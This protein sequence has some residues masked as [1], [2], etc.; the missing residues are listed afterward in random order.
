MQIKITHNGSS[1]EICSV[2]AQLQSW[3]HGGR[4]YIWQREESVWTSSCPILFPV[5]GSTVDDTVKIGGKPYGI[6]KHGFT[7]AMDFSLGK[8][9]DDFAELLL[10]DTPE[11]YAV[12]PFHFTLHVTFVIED[13]KIST[14]LLVENRDDKP[15]PF[16]LGGHPGFALP[17]EDGEGFEDNDIVFEQHEDGINSLAPNGYIIT[18]TE[19]L[20][21]MEDGRVLPLKYSLFD[22]RDALIFA[23]LKSRSVRLVSRNTGRGIRF[24]F[25]KFSVLGIWSKP[26]ANADYVCLEPWCGI[27]AVKGESGSMEDKPYVQIIPP[28]TCARFA[29]SAS[30]V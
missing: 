6:K 4:E 27:P 20:S 15:M 3:K 7:R 16:C 8:H 2:G 5:V 24:D 10:S 29:F 28:D 11:T 22:E 17:F 14:V 18:G 23:S 21:E 13:G 1:A 25:P 12:Y 26:K 9:G 30:A 19:K